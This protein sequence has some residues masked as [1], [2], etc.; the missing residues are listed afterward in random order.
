MVV[1]TTMGRVLTD[2]EDCNWIIN[3]GRTFRLTDIGVFGATRLREF[4][5]A[6][7]VECSLRDVWP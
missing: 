1:P 3:T 4:R 6:M 2:F 7:S 5:D